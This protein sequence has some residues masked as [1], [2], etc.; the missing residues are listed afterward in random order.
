MKNYE[1]QIARNEKIRQFMFM[2]QLKTVMDKELRR[3]SGNK[4]YAIS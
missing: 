4:K 1:G 2:A 3:K